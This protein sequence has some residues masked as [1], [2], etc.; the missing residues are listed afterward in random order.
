MA[1]SPALA[2]TRQ[3]SWVNFY[4]KSRQ[5]TT[6]LASFDLPQR[7]F[8]AGQ[9]TAPLSSPRGEA[10]RGVAV[11]AAN[12]SNFSSCAAGGSDSGSAFVPQD[13]WLRMGDAMTILGVCR[14]TLRKYCQDG[15][16]KAFKLNNCHWR[17]SLN[18]INSLGNIDVL[19]AAHLR[20]LGAL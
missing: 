18:S 1:G 3:V 14:K 2:A 17:I 9:P 13:R 16:V 6:P 4:M 8:P 12:R 5:N 19:V 10:L 11:M 15:T 20:K 7:K